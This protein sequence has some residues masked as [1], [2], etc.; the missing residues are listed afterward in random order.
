MV[1]KT[2]IVYFESHLIAGLGLPP[3][4]F[5]ISILNFLGCELVH[6]NPNDIVVLSCFSMLC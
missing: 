2:T 6:L 3:I 4:K 1:D 5:L